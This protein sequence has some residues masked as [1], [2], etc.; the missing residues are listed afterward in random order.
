VVTVGIATLNLLTA[1]VVMALGGESTGSEDAGI[2]VIT[3]ASIVGGY[4]LLAGLWY[5]VF[6]GKASKGKRGS[7]RGHG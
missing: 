6:R 5:F 2:A 1:A 3:L 7:G 4:V